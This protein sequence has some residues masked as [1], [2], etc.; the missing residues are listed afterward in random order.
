MHHRGV[1]MSN[2]S[3]AKS[4]IIDFL[5]STKDKEDYTFIHNGNEAEALRFIARMRTELTRLRSL[6]L[7]EGRTLSRF[8]VLTILIEEFLDRN[9][10]LKC[11]ITLRK[12]FDKKG[13][14]EDFVDSEVID[15]LVEAAS[16]G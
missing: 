8:K 9:E 7:S 13:R 16:N 2:R 10:I 3:P 1:S 4:Q 6:A 12:A 14:L 15:E 5:K 11:K